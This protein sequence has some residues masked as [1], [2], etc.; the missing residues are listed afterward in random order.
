MKILDA[1]VIGLPLILPL[2]GGPTDYCEPDL[3]WPAKFDQVEVGDCLET[4]E[5]HWNEQLTWCEPRVGDLAR[6]MRAVYEQQTEAKRRAALLRERVI[7]DFSWAKAAQ[8]LRE[9][10]GL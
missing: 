5:L 8:K 7:R 2:Y 4:R 1:A 6:Q 10:L 3:V 9:A